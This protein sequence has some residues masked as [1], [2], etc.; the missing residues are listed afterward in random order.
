MWLASCGNC[1]TSVLPSGGTGGK[2]ESSQRQVVLCM[3]EKVDP[4][5]KKSLQQTKEKKH[6]QRHRE[7]GALE[8][9]G[10]V[11]YATFA[12]RLIRHCM[13]LGNKCDPVGGP[14]NFSLKTAR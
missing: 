7:R 9:A 1:S 11:A 14:S 5:P 13:V 3:V 10:S 4:P 8:S 2:Y 12:A 6:P